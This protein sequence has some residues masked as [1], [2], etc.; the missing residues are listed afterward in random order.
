MKNDH[1]VSM[2]AAAM[3][4]AILGFAGA[5]LVTMQVGTQ[6]GSTNDMQSKQ[7]FYV[8]NA[9][10]E[11]ALYD[12]YWGRNPTTSNM[13]FAMGN[14]STSTDPTAGLT[15]VSSQVGV[16][17]KTQTVAVQ[18]S[19]SC[20]SLDATKAAIGDD[21][22]KNDGVS[23][24]DLLNITLTKSCNGTATISQMWVDWNWDSCVLN[25]TYSS[26]NDLSS[27][28]VSHGGSK[29]NSIKIG[30]TKIYD[31]ATTGTPTGTG[32][33]AKQT[34]D[35][36]D[37]SMSSNATTTF[38]NIGFTTAIPNGALTTLT[39]QFADG[40][41]IS[42]TFQIKT[43]SSF[44]INNGTLTVNANKTLNLQ[45]ICTEITYGAGGPT[46]PVKTKLG[47]G[48][49]W[50]KLWNYSAVQKGWTY[51]TSVG[52]TSQSYK[53]Q[54]YAKYGSWSRT[55]DSTNT[56]QVKTLKNGDQAPALA[57]YGGQQSVAQCL[58]SYLNSSTGKVV[59][60]GNQA[61]ML[62]ELGVDMSYNSTSSAADFQDLVMLY[63]IQ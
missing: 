49:T 31:P 55:Y 54:G 18:F 6:Q 52:A 11:K 58:S 2:L 59:L 30:G 29:V 53:L 39:I 25:G 43:A 26:S 34:I 20:V 60:T 50:N 33:D 32:A 10:L 16:A 57:G 36:A 44:T 19:K 22:N 8:G 61:I 24:N 7:A 38:D 63:T 9:G 23:T 45:V 5:A 15:T 27:C 28:A 46:I 17:K 42:D 47:I 4:L 48:S 21:P 56:A 40:S 13:K 14:F 35:V 62:F 3:V 12:V 51:S 37:Y 1:G 41:Q